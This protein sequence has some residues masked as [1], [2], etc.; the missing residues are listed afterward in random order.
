MK[1]FLVS[2][3]CLLIFAGSSLA[4][5]VLFNTKTYKYHKPSCQ[6]A[7][8]CTVNCIRIEKQQAKQRGGV[9]CKVCGG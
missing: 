7:K 4:E 9:P 1:K 2:L 8:K 3:V 5:P 6:H